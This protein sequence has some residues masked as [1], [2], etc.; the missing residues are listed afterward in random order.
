MRE[1]LFLE[2]TTETDLGAGIR[3]AD[4]E[5]LGAVSMRRIAIELG[6][7]TMALY[8]HVRGKNQL[9]LQMADS[10]MAQPPLP[11]MPPA[12]WRAQLEVV[13]RVQWDMYRRHPW[14]AR[15]IS[16]TRPN[17][18][19]HGMAHTEWV[20]RALDGYGLDPNTLLHLVVTL[21]G[22]V[23]GCA[24]NVEMQ[25]EA[26]Q[27]SGLTDEEWI[28]SQSTNFARFLESGRY[29]KLRFITEAPGVNL[30]V[31]SLFEFGLHRLLDGYAAF[32]HTT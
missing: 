4:A 19:P 13:A 29:P 5:G 15:V 27:D 31:D 18:A 24:M 22:Y 10:I 25:A 7:P 3:I 16:M 11:S 14:M 1:N 8:R 30:D 12:G 6:L 20:L 9:V 28:A 32:L 2:I 21:F 26:E 23:R 17:L